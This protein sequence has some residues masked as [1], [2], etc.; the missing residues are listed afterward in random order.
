M[1]INTPVR[2]LGQVD[3]DPLR[4][5]LLNNKQS[6]WDLTTIRQEEFEVHKA[7]KSI[8]MIFADIEQWPTI[9]IRKEEGWDILAK[10]ALPIMNEIIQSNY[11][12]GG[13]VIRAMAAKLLPGE[14]IASHWDSHPSFHCGHR[15]HL[16]IKT[17]S[18]VRFN[19]DGFPY[20]FNVGEAYELNNQKTH[21]VINKGAEERIH[22]I[23]D[24][25]PLSELEKL[26]AILEQ[27]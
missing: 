21:S 16:P 15:I 12:P 14:N 20:Q 7:T 13:T 11:N 25:V 23:F 18:R 9:E 17:N 8:V 3:I 26:P 4:E 22:F 24:Y 27:N 19:I 10:V 1:N 6:A 5:V 2:E